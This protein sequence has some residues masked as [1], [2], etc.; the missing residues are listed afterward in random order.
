MIKAIVPKDSQQQLALK[1]IKMQL[2]YSV[3]FFGGICPTLFSV[4]LIQITLS[5]HLMPHSPII[6]SLQDFETI[7][8]GVF[9]TRSCCSAFK[10]RRSVFDFTG[11]FVEAQSSSCLPPVSFSWNRYLLKKLSFLKTPGPD[12]KPRAPRP[13]LELTPHINVSDFKSTW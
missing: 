2:I 3:S 4:L 1:T 7:R 10:G 8:R 5:I 12:R 13:R 9:P 6:C 11:I